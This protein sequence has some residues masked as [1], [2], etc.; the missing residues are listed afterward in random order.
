MKKLRQLGVLC[1]GVSLLPLS[2]VSS[3]QAITLSV[4]DNLSGATFL[5][6]YGGINGSFDV[7]GV[8]SSSDYNTPYSITSATARFYF[9]DDGDLT[10]DYTGTLSDYQFNYTDTGT[11][12]SYYE[13][14]QGTYYYDTSDYSQAT[15]FNGVT[16]QVASGSSSYFSTGSYN[17]H[18]DDSDGTWYDYYTGMD[19]YYTVFYDWDYGYTGSWVV[20]MLLDST[21]I[22]ALSDDGILDFTAEALYG[23]DTYFDNATLTFNVEMNPVPV[24][25]AVWL[26]GSGLLGLVSM[27]RRKKAA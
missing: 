13:R 12:W 17:H 5:A 10:Y 26:F 7:N 14:S 15:I 22:A 16:N 23:Y 20:E 21:S 25:A 11:G 1:A 24:P 8:L 9:T 18:T 3:A 19:I 4:D 2:Y 27:A 6:A